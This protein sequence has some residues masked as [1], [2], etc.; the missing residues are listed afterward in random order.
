MC[1]IFVLVL[2]QMHQLYKTFV[3]LTALRWVH[4]WP[5]RLLAYL[6][7][8][9]TF[10]FVRSLQKRNQARDERIKATRE[11]LEG[12]GESLDGRDESCMHR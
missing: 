7:D 8:I 10:L 2:P 3:L 9:C 4:T 12:R 1:M 11:Q 5:R 6:V